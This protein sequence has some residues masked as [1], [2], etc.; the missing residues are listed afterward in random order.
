[1]AWAVEVCEEFEA[2]WNGLSEDE[3]V[4]I[5]SMVRVLETHA[6]SLEMFSVRAVGSRYENLRQ[7][8]VPHQDRE[9]CVAYVSDEARQVLVLLIGTTT[10]AVGGDCPPE[11]V[12]LAERVYERHLLRLG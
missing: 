12:D 3:R 4:S 6:P 1:M 8:L 7:L 10:P 5:D 11:E 9:M 2:W